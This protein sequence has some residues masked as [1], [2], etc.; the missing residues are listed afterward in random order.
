MD[1]LSL[2]RTMGALGVVLGLLGG[3]LWVVRRYNIALPGRVTLGRGR[4]LE[5]VER[6][7]L[8][9]K[10]SLALVR[11]D[12]CE[13]L[14]LI[15]PDGQMVVESGI[16][17]SIP[18]DG[19]AAVGTAMAG[20]AIAQTVV[21]EMAARE[22]EGQA[23]EPTPGN[24]KDAIVSDE[25]APEPET[26]L[27][28]ALTLLLDHLQSRRDK[29]ALIQASLSPSREQS[30]P[31]S[32]VASASSTPRRSVSALLDHLTEQHHRANVVA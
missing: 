25:T 29:A 30:L 14:I 22:R 11:R 7:T 6:V 32:A 1:V 24:S 17:P 8:D 9:G 26:E 3:A 20:E 12:G 4:R 21:P 2:L 13:H 15:G 28:T 31:V 10:R 23:S 27:R 19:A 18:S 5:V 16:L